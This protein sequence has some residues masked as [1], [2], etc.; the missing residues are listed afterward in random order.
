MILFRNQK[1]FMWT[2][3]DVT[4]LS[5]TCGCFQDMTFSV[6]FVRLPPHV[7][8][9]MSTSPLPRHSCSSSNLSLILSLMGVSSKM[10]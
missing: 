7:C 3:Q 4:S 6:C 10:T 5:S 2:S 9:L 1:S 8:C